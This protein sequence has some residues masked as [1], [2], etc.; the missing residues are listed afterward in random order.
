MSEHKPEIDSNPETEKRR[1]FL[2]SLAM[3][4]PATG[5]VAIGVAPPAQAETLGSEPAIESDPQPR[6]APRGVSRARFI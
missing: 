1:G 5:A 2:K 3:M 4:V 6:I